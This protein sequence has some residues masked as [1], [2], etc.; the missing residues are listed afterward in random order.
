MQLHVHADRVVAEGQEALLGRRAEPPARDLL[1][2]ARQE[3]AFGRRVRGR[4]VEQLGGSGGPQLPEMESGSRVWAVSL[5][6]AVVGG[7]LYDVIPM[8][9]SSWLIYVADVA[10][11]GLPA[12]LIMAALSSRIRSEALMHGEVDTLLESVNTAMHDLLADEGFFATIIL[13]RYWPAIGRMQ[14]AIGGHLPPLWVVESGA[15]NIPH[16]KGIALG[17]AA[18]AK[19]EKTEIVLSPGE[20]ILFI[21]DGVTEAENDQKELLGHRRLVDYT[22]NATGPPWGR[23]LLDTVRVWRGTMEPNDDLTIVEIW[24]ESQ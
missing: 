2:Q 10:D 18:G 1:E 9:D 16:T 22:Q 6:A 15:A 5:P 14:L 4:R 24:R 3:H 19:Y 20:S 21:T 12:A 11:K 8:P 23:G 17:I 13:S 7:D